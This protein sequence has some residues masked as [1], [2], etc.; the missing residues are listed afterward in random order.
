M[1]LRIEDTQHVEIKLGGRKFFAGLLPHTVRCKLMK[2]HLGSPV[3]D[4]VDP[5]IKSDYDRIFRN[6]AS[7]NTAIYDQIDG[8]A[9][10]YRCKTLNQ[11]TSALS[12]YVNKSIHDLMIQRLLNGIQGFVVLWPLDFLIN[13]DTSPS[14]ASKLIIPTNLWV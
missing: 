6:I 3:L 13:D 11:Y 12:S 1:A 2:Q 8:D 7:N 5:V 14:Q 10:P 4:V 9:S